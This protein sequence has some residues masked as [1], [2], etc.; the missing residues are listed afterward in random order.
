MK[1]LGQGSLAQILKI[2]LDIVYYLLWAG[3]VLA[4]LIIVLIVFGGLYRLLGS[5]PDL[6][7]GL[8]QFLAMDVVLALPL[9]IAALATLTFVVDRLRRIGATLIA[10]DPFVAEN[11]NHLRA[12]AIGIGVYQLLH[13]AAHGVLAL[14]FTLLGRSVESGARVVPEFSLNLS[15][16]FAVLAILVLSE[17]FREGTRMREEQKLTI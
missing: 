4:S 14:L 8:M 6:P 3:L 13:Y 9:A 17:I 16:W 15:A 11:S 2:L 12:I 5:G 10:G 1:A 7:P